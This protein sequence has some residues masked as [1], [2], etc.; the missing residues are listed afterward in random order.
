MSPRQ[1]L[2]DKSR[3]VGLRMT[4]SETQHGLKGYII[5]HHGKE[6]TPFKTFCL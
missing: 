1:V 5:R 4:V 3:G 2:F 6:E